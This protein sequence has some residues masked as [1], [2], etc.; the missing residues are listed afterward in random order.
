MEQ[1]KL[2]ETFTRQQLINWIE[3]EMDAF[4]PGIYDLIDKENRTDREN[5]IVGQWANM[6]YLKKR[7]YNDDLNINK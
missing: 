5:Y 7:I 4:K 2:N 1:S 6:K 3:S